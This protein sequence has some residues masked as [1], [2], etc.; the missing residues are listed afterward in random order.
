MM[1][2]FVLYEQ[3][4]WLQWLNLFFFV[5]LPFPLLIALLAA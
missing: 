4:R 3:L 1:R 2:R 5:S